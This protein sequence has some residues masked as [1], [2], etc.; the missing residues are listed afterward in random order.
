MRFS[1]IKL[2]SISAG[3]GGIDIVNEAFDYNLDELINLLKEQCKP[4]PTTYENVEAKTKNNEISTDKEF[5]RAFG[6]TGGRQW[7]WVITNNGKDITVIVHRRTKGTGGRNYSDENRSFTLISKSEESIIESQIII[8]GNTANPLNIGQSKTIGW[9]YNPEVVLQINYK[10]K[11]ILNG[12][13]YTCMSNPTNPCMEENGAY[14][15]SLSGCY[16]GSGITVSNTDN[17]TQ[18][19]L[20]GEYEGASTCDINAA[21]LFAGRYLSCR[22]G[23]A[24]SPLKDCCKSVEPNEE[25]KKGLK[26]GFYTGMLYNPFLI[27]ATAFGE[28]ME[29][30]GEGNLIGEWIE[31][32]TSWLSGGVCEEGEIALS[33]LKSSGPNDGN[34]IKLGEICSD[35]RGAWGTLPVG[36][37]DTCWYTEIQCDRTAEVY[38]CFDDMMAKATAKAGREQLG[39]GWGTDEGGNMITKAN[40]VRPG[41]NPCNPD[42][43]RFNFQCRG[44]TIQEMVSLN[45]NTE[46]YRNDIREYADHLLSKL[47]DENGQPIGKLQEIINDKSIAEKLKESLK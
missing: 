8:D 16:K 28:I 7:G 39:I 9:D 19:E 18:E 35:Y 5:K 27:L 32:A 4:S 22:H 6:D 34:C 13:K 15:C 1:T 43:K 3:C 45:L 40:S 36:G 20:Q 24:T 23:S 11:T 46:T 21:S 41:G 38:C 14:Y 44:L 47:V 33:T 31:S 42:K 12:Y 29:L 26:Y 17:A 37:G 30:L 25:L 2:P 10:I